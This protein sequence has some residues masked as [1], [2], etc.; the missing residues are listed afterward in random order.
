MT[1]RGRGTVP[2]F[3][4]AREMMCKIKEKR[5]DVRL[6]HKLNKLSDLWVLVSGW[7]SKRESI[8]VTARQ[9]QHA[10]KPTGLRVWR[11]VTSGVF[12][13]LGS[14]RMIKHQHLLVTIPPSLLRTQPSTLII[15]A[16]N[17]TEFATPGK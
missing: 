17:N 11:V 6:Q 3:Q 12:R 9:Q 1:M 4:L 10:V 13:P 14:C 16:L 15:L 5:L 8:D 2:S 7:A